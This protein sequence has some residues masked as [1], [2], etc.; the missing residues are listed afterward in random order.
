MHEFKVGDRV[1]FAAGGAFDVYRGWANTNRY[2]TGT[3]IEVFETGVRVQWD[4]DE[5]T[6]PCLQSIRLFENDRK[7]QHYDMIV[8]WASGETIQSR[9]AG[10][11]SWRDVISAPDW[12]ATTEYRIK[13]KKVKKIGWVNIYPESRNGEYVGL[14]SHIYETEEKA[15]NSKDEQR[16]ACIKIEWEEEEN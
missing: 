2:D 16:V 6:V 12:A 11:L 10:M 14:S 4:S 9:P 15:N 5:S 7:H 13:P 1:E 8:A 3:V